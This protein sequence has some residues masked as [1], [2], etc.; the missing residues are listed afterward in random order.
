LTSQRVL[1]ADLSVE[2]QSLTQGLYFTPVTV[3]VHIPEANLFE[4]GEAASPEIQEMA[5]GGS[6]TGLTTLAGTISADI[7]TE[8]TAGPLSPTPKVSGRFMT[9]D[10]NTLLSAVA[11]TLPCNDGFID[12]ENWAISTEART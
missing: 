10:G 9:T 4:V 11:I 12:L 3:V 5:K 1:A 6:L 2:V 8:P 7:L